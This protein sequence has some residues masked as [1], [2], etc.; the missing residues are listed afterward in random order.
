MESRST[1]HCGHLMDYCVSPGWLRLW[2]NRWNDWQGKQEYSEKTCPSAALSTTKPTCFSYVKPG[3]YGEKPACNR[4]ATA[5][6]VEALCY[7]PEGHGIASRWGVFFSNLTNPSGLNVTLGSTQPLTEMSTRNLKK[8]TW[9]VKGGRSLGLATLPRYVRRLSK[10][11][12]SLDL[13][14]PYGTPRPVTGIP[15]LLPFIHVLSGIL[16]MIP[17]FERVKT[18][19][20]LDGAATVISITCIYRRIWIRH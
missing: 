12:G 9:R 11:R 20:A 19:Y 15:L 18:F 17:V 10:K 5:R 16:P 2:R 3:R 1:R 8:E 7:K 13:S 4:W 6:P 14:Q